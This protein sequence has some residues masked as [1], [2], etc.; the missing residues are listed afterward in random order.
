MFVRT[1][2]PA[3]MKLE[4]SNLAQIFILMNSGAGMF[5]RSKVKVTGSIS[6]K[7]TFLLITF[8]AVVTSQMHGHKFAS[9]S[10]A[11]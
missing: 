4:C 1:I 2:A 6:T 5:L 9:P 8:A 10:S 3:P 7:N 11:V